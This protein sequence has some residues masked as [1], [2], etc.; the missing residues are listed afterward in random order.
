MHE[1][2]EICYQKRKRL[3]SKCPLRKGLL[4]RVVLT[5]SARI[6]CFSSQI[7]STIVA[8]T[9]SATRRAVTTHLSLFQQNCLIFCY[10]TRLLSNTLCRRGPILLS[11]LQ[12]TPRENFTASGGTLAGFH[13]KLRRIQGTVI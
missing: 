6:S 1:T 4:T 11:L 10:I 7:T 13:V 12:M 9:H 3:L 2:L 5:G 8:I